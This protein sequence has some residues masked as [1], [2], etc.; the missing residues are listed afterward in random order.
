MKKYFSLTLVA[1]AVISGIAGYLL[2]KPASHATAT[3]AAS[4]EVAAE[5]SRKVLYWYDPMSPGQR[6]DKPGK[7]PFMD[8]ELVPR[9]AGETVEDG[10][11]TISA[12][13]QQNLGLRTAPAEMRTLN[14]R[15]TGYGTVATDERSV[16]VI[17]ARANGIIE[18][19]YVR[20]NQQ[21]V[22]KNQS[23]AQ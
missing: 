1:V 11:V 22:T 2:G 19:L 10:G 5:N 18:Q 7:S 17:A 23:I 14:Y 3:V 16:Q 9:Y 15:L 4:P 20:A 8:M 6:F 12:R 21:P 13:Q